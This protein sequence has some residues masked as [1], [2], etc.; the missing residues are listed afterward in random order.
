MISIGVLSGDV[1]VFG[2]VLII[3]VAL[4]V[5]PQL[6]I[7]YIEYRR[8]EEME[9]RF[10]RFLRDL[11]ESI[12]AGMPLHKAIFAARHT[13]YGPLSDEVGRMANQLSWN[14][15]IL[16]VLEGSKERLVESKVLTKIYRIM[17]ETYKSGGS[18]SE[19]LDSLSTTL[20]TIQET[21]KERKSMLNQYVI[22][23]YAISFIFIGIVVGINR[24][25]VPIFISIAPG[26]PVGEF[27]ANP[28]SQC[29]YGGGLSCSPCNLYFNVCS[30]FGVEKTGVSCYYLALF[31]FMSTIQ[32]ITGGLVV[33]QIGEGS[34]KAGIKHSL[35]LFS[36]AFGAF[37]IL[38]KVKLLGV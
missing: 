6:I 15:N 16:K 13:D 21:Q 24:L 19:T 25:M 18:V 36:V 35:I 1:G 29:L 38:V 7:D 4:M 28:C 10:P 33:G 30:M 12:R 8:L 14:I 37:F 22:A 9:L 26:G 3:S 31:F 17:L 2:N 34:I 5:V 20:S 27:V 11:V 23:T 32:A